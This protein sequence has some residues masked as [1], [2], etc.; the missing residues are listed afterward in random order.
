MGVMAKIMN[1][2]N[3]IKIGVANDFSKYPGARYKTDG[4]F[5][6]QE[7]YEVILKPNLSKIWADS[8]SAINLNLDG[9]FGYASSFISEIFTSVVRDFKDKEL[10]KKKIVLTS[11]DEPLLVRTIQQIIDEA[12]AGES[13]A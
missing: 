12:E 9:T 13:Q 2:F 3:E 11:N 4:D 5:S 1:N 7:F 6:G 10:I 8:N